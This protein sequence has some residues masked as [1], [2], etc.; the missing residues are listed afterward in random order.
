MSSF[1]LE[2][3]KNRPLS[4][5][6]D[7]RERSALDFVRQN[8]WSNRAETWSTA[9]RFNRQKQGSTP[10][11]PL[12]SYICLFEAFAFNVALIFLKIKRRVQP[13]LTRIRWNCV[14]CAFLNNVS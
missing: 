6:N 4:L 11:A 10:I 9:A 12:Y 3:L 5:K 14:S 1:V 8:W 13:G 7:S 2:Y